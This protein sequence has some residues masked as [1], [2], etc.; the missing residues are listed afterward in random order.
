MS[1]TAI[2]LTETRV[3]TLHDDVPASGVAERRRRRNPPEDDVLQASR[4]ADSEAPDGGYGWVVVTAGAVLLWW[5]MGTTYAWGILQA[6]LVERG[7][8]G[9][10][11]LSFVG[12][13]QAALISALAI[14]NT[15]LMRVLG[16][17]WMAMLG[18]GFLGLSAIFSGF[19]VDNIGALFFTSGILMGMG[20]R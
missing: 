4:A 6:A 13:L 1:T 2:Q 14:V 8:A 15:R 3:P 9:P 19:A 17:R 11:T 20:V 16:T 12:S 18:V 7:L 10:A 5:S